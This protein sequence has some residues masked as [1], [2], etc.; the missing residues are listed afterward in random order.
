MSA[1]CRHQRSKGQTGG[2]DSSSGAI[3]MVKV[4][5]NLCPV[6]RVPV[7]RCNDANLTNIVFLPMSEMQLFFLIYG[8]CLM[9]YLMMSWIF[10]RKP[11]T[12]LKKLISVLMF[13]ILMQYVK[14]LF[15][16]GDTQ[17]ADGVANDAAASLDFVAVPFYCL[18]MF[19]LCRPGWLTV[20][21]ALFVIMP[22][23]VL[24]LLY[25]IT[26]VELIFMLSVYLS[27]ASGLFCA[28]WSF[29]EIPA[30]HRRLKE[31]YSYD[32]YIN[33]HWLRGVTVMFFLLLFV[34]VL[35]CKFTVPLMQN[36]YMLCS[37]ACWLVVCFFI[38]RQQ[39]VFNAVREHE[40]VVAEVPAEEPEAAPAT[41]EDIDRLGE[42]LR[43]LFTEER[44][45]LDPKLRLTDLAQRIG[46][47][48]TYLSQYFNQ[49]CSQS[50]YEYVNNF[51]LAHSE[52]LLRETDYTLDVVAT[53]SGFNSLSTFRRAFHLSHGC[54]AQS[55]RAEKQKDTKC[56]L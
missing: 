26:Q 21:G 31:E 36:A 25:I 40:A 53:M 37:L 13:I 18:I 17:I 19:E 8:M 30:Y 33:L 27:F 11:R 54:S 10:I 55:Y 14:D 9:F 24:S 51:R 42:R 2:G 20:R 56:N 41:T 29:V 46:T 22:F 28:I 48:R 4:C 7:A 50:F 44:I 35:S 3:Y 47:N 49:A 23:I 39:N 6:A 5:R 45:Y 12:R 15:F 43:V 34:W 52:R 32:E 1:V 16:L 38:H